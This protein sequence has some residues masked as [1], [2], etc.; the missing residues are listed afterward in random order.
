[1]EKRNTKK[2]FLWIVGILKKHKIPFQITGGCAARAYGSKRPLSDID[3]DVPENA[4]KQIASE[5]KDYIK[6]GPDRYIDD[7]FDLMLL[8]LNFEGQEIDICGDVCKTRSGVGGEWLGSKTDFSKY[9]IKELYGT[10]VPVENKADLIKY[11]KQMARE[12]D[13]EDIKQMTLYGKQ[14]Q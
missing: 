8:T 5:A 10:K 11:K 2:A 7:N 13:L 14:N 3:I 9:E 6:R 1:M 4:I 12:V